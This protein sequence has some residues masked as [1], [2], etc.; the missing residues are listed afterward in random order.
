MEKLLIQW[1]PELR[2]HLKSLPAPITVAEAITDIVDGEEMFA[3]ESEYRFVNTP[4]FQSSQVFQ[5]TGHYKPIS[6]MIV[7]IQK[8]QNIPHE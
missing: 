1:C 3:P 6:K 8:K 7:G 5:R 2:L 4:D